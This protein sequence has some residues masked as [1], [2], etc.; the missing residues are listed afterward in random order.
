MPRDATP[1]RRP[2]FWLMGCAM[3]AGA[4]AWLSAQPRAP[5][6]PLRE[7]TAHAPAPAP[8]RARPLGE[9]IARDPDDVRAQLDLARR[10]IVTNDLAGASAQTDAVL[11]R[12]ARHPRALTYRAMI[13]LARGRGDDAIATLRAVIASA[14]DLVEAHRI[15]VFAYASRGRRTEAEAAVQELTRRV[16]EEGVKL[17]RALARSFPESPV[18]Q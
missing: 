17:A 1:D 3:A 12:S 11:S 13:D 6:T 15:L 4:L 8:D 9:S 18:A 7:P 2:V 14:P 10:L 16:P 5:L